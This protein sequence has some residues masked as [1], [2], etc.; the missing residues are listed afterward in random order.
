MVMSKEMERMM[1]EGFALIQG[2]LGMAF[3]MLAFLIGE[4]LP[5]DFYFYDLWKPVF[6]FLGGVCILMTFANLGKLLKMKR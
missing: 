3:I 2:F 1:Y 6:L 5:L 4:M